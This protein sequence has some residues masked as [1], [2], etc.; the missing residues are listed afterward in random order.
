MK[1][2]HYI[3]FLRIISMFAI[4]AAHTIATPVISNSKDYSD[5]WLH[6]SVVLAE[7]CRGGVNVFIAISGALFLQP[8]KELTLSKLFKKYVTRII[9]A[10]IIFG[11]LFSLMEIVFI[12]KTFTFSQISEALLRMVQNE[13][14]GH[15]WYLYMLVGI[16]LVTPVF[17]RFVQSANNSEIK[18]TIEI[19]FL[20]NIIFPVI[21]KYIDIKIGFYIPF[22]G[23][24]IFFYLLGYALHSR[25]IKIPNILSITMIVFSIFIFFLE[26]VLD[27][28]INIAGVYFEGFSR[29]TLCSFL[30]PVSFYSLALN[31][32]KE[33]SGRFDKSLSEL[34]FGVYI[35][36]AVFINI[37]YKVL[38]LTPVTISVP[39]MWLI[40]FI[41]TS[42]LSITLTY[43]LRFIPIIRKYV[44]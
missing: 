29:T 44:L 25:I 21:E 39:I 18:Y 8:E 4:I 36:H 22:V 15:L 41:A 30:I 12:E 2:I 17:K 32:C 40:V 42:I 9:I 1:N 31:Y 28:E 27:T 35:F 3:S 34:S 7:I 43:V 5:F 23:T 16:Y 33:E 11:T 10:L 24:P 13:S 20:F 14:W 26:C 6:L 19:I 37:I 38:H